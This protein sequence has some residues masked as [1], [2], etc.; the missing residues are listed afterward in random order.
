MNTNMLQTF[1]QLFYKI[2][3]KLCL[4]YQAKDKINKYLTRTAEVKIALIPPLFTSR[5]PVT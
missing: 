3:F 1:K 2:H 5:P 4:T